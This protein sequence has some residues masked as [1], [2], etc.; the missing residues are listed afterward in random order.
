MYA[1]TRSGRGAT[2][3]GLYVGGAALVLAF[4]ISLMAYISIGRNEA[5]MARLLAE[6]GCSLVIAIESALR[7][8]MR[9]E[10]GVHLQVLLEEVATSPGLVFI[11]VPM[12]DGTIVAHSNRLRLGG[13][14]RLDDV[15]MDEARMRD[16]NPG[17]L[18]QW[19]SMHMEGQRVF[20]VYRQLSLG[21]SG[22]GQTSLGRESPMRSIT[23][24]LSLSTSLTMALAAARPSLSS[25][26]RCPK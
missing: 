17:I 12:P 9:N 5:G 19:G 16:L 2:P 10:A 8:G 14:L 1:F 20:V 25:G 23:T 11:A 6:K 4:M 24:R 7:S 15:E 26:N 21:L 3:P 18:A 22:L 13:I